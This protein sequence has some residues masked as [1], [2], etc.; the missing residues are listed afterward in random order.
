MLKLFVLFVLFIGSQQLR[1]IFVDYLFIWDE[2]QAA[3]ALG[4]AITLGLTASDVHLIVIRQFGWRR[5]QPGGQPK[6]T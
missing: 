4:K 6:H 1:S 5:R 3:K 2:H